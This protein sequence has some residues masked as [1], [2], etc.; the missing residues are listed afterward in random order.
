MAKKFLV[1]LDLNK[2]ELLNARLQNLSSDPSSPV[3]GQIYY[4]TQENVTKFYDGTQ[5]IAGGSTKFGNTASRP[6]ASKAG[7]LYIDTETSTIFLDNGTSWIQATVNASDVSDAIDAHNDLTT[8]VHGVTG[9][10]VGT[11]DI[12]DLSNKRIIDTL[13]FSDGVTLADE[14]E[15]AVLAGSHEFEIKANDGN[16]G[17]KTVATNADVVITSDSGDI[18][19]NPDGIAKVNGVLN[20]TN[21]LNITTISGADFDSR[22]GSLTLQDETG[23]SQI[24]INGDTKNIEL[25][26]ASGSKAFYGSAATAGNEI[27]KISDLQA[28]S[29]GLSWKQ[30]V[31]LLSDSNVDVEADFVGTIID[32]HSALDTSDSGY[33]LLLTGQTDS[34]ENGIYVLTQSGAT[35][36]ASRALDAD[37]DAELK[38]AAVFVMEGT[39]YGS[40]SWVQNNHYI[41]SF[42]D[43]DWVQ[44]SGQGTLIGSDSIQ[45]DGNEINVI[46][47][48][49]RGIAID[50]DGVYAKIGNGIEFDGSGNIAINP[51]TGFDISSGALE[52]ASSYGVRKYT[53]SI[54]NSSAT[55]FN[56]DHNF[57]TRHVTVQIFESASPYAQ[58]EADVEHTTSNRVTVKFASAPGT[59]EYEVVIVG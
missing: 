54:G 8:G 10:V 58:V 38:G 43:Q 31:N 20:V 25:L 57:D 48:T 33:R 14:G 24:H 11:S 46:A 41:S 50:G 30:A 6:T 59:G 18:V 1:S 13:S 53:T 3:A 27:A 40:T 29:S 28:L 12:Q 42:A 37:S 47:D 51:G 39:N 52:F 9:D 35:L 2:N 7:T 17:L 56:L 45:I 5:W 4:N 16:L 21:T 23:T 44:F 19:L 26:P 22:D 15:I 34:T 49:T 55:S 36:V 32:G